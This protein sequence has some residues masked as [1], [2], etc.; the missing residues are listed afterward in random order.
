MH[1]LVPT[2]SALAVMATVIAEVH[3][4]KPLLTVSTP[5]FNNGG[6][7]PSKYTC[8]G[9][10]I[11]PA[12]EIKD[13]PKNAKSIVIT[14]DDPDAANGGFDHWVVWNIPPT[15]TIQENNILGTTG[16]NGAGENKYK[17]PCPPTGTHHYNFKVYALDNVLDVNKDSDRKAIEKAIVGHILAAG[18]FTGLYQKQ[19]TI[20]V[21][22]ELMEK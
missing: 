14:L 2:I 1:L 16:K 22:K 11:N 21:E 18:Q 7:I 3:K 8:E 6:K 17:G 15:T 9:E 12:I 4:T 20:A 19:K 13:L 10:N 5:A